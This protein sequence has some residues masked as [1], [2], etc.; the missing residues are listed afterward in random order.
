MV[1]PDVL[2]EFVR[3]AEADI[4]SFEARMREVSP[5]YQSGDRVL[6][7]GDL[8]EVVRYQRDGMPGYWLKGQ[9]CAQLFWPVD[10]ERVLAPVVH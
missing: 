2:R 5:A 3:L 1:H 10:L 6:A 7:L 4:A 9:G 8:F